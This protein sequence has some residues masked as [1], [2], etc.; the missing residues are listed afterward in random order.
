MEIKT[1]IF[2]LTWRAKWL[3]D[4]VKSVEGM[5]QAL[6]AEAAHLRTLAAE[7]VELKEEV[8]DDYAFLR[9]TDPRVAARYDFEA[10]EE[11]AEEDGALVVVGVAPVG[12]LGSGLAATLATICAVDGTIGI[13]GHAESI[14]FVRPE[15]AQRLMQ[16]RETNS[17]EPLA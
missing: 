14:E 11:Q 4:G 7:G 2:E 16:V 12:K 17:Q 13:L 8:E 10:V 1:D 15:V 3:A 5:A 6:E 9:T